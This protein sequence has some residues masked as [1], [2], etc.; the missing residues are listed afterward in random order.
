MFKWESE[1]LKMQIGVIFKLHRLRK[2]LSQF[3][4]GNE[5]D[6]TKD[7]IGIIERGKANPTIEVLIKL[8]NFLEVD[9]NLLV[10]KATSS[11]LQAFKLEILELDARFKNQNKRKS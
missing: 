7:Y 8:C 2:K 1:E 5:V 3:Q 11:Q 9:I 6:L 10:T 4:V